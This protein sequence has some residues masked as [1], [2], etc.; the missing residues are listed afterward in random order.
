MSIADA[1]VRFI[2]ALEVS[3]AR[4]DTR[5]DLGTFLN[6]L[7]PRDGFSLRLPF[8]YPGPRRKVERGTLIEGVD[9]VASKRTDDEREHL[10]LFVLAREDANDPSHLPEVMDR[11]LMAIGGHAPSDFIDLFIDE[12]ICESV[13]IVAVDNG[14][15]DREALAHWRGAIT[16][17][18]RDAG[19]ELLWWPVP[20]LVDHGLVALGL[21]H[22]ETVFPPMIRAFYSAVRSGLE[23]RGRLELE[24]IDRLLHQRLGVDPAR[25]IADARYLLSEL[26]LFTAMLTHLDAAR[27]TGLLDVIDALYRVATASIAAV[28][29][30]P[31]GR[32]DAVTVETLVDQLRTFVEVGERLADVLTPLSEVP[33]GLVVSG[34]SE[35]IDWPLRTTRLVRDLAVVAHVAGELIGRM[36]G[37]AEA[38]DEHLE[39]MVEK[40]IRVSVGLAQNN[41]G[42]LCTPIVDDQLIEHAIIWRVWLAHGMSETV[43][44]MAEQMVQRWRLRRYMGLP[45]PGLYQHFSAPMQDRDTQVLAEV[46]SDPESRPPAFEEGG[47]TLLPV[48]LVVASRLGVSFEPDVI[49]AFGAITVGG[50]E[51]PA[52]HAQSWSLPADAPSR[53]YDLSED[54]LNRRGVCRVHALSDLPMFLARF[55]EWQ[56]AIETSPARQMGLESLDLMAWVRWRVRPPVRWLL[57]ALPGEG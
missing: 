7:L 3:S 16:Q 41:E 25:S 1:L 42:G 4:P 20:T 9:L 43:R 37:R 31:G 47:S 22:D 18:I 26:S 29:T 10:Y 34:G 17:R 11:A 8:R 49:A 33:E 39:R 50:R 21:P 30:V 38:D 12:G 14:V 5:Q 27:S 57:D 28:L 2:R 56:V 32:E 36:K 46:W 53:W 45:G 19:F 13:S 54:D 35:K 6:W 48:A 40:C 51:R 15:L 44:R 52:I 23:T 55:A 24:A